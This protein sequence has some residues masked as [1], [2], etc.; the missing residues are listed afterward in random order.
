VDY[1]ESWSCGGKSVGSEAGEP[2]RK[3]KVSLKQAR[4]SQLDVKG[5]GEERDELGENGE[6]KP[7]GPGEDSAYTLKRRTASAN[8]KWSTDP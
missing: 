7:K 6:K 5:E 1:G 2:T 4:Y 8:A 3:V